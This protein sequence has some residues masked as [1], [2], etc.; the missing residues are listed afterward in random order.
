[1][2]KLPESMVERQLEKLQ[3]HLFVAYKQTDDTYEGELKPEVQ[4]IIHDNLQMNVV[5]DEEALVKILHTIVKEL[6]EWIKQE[7]KEI[8]EEILYRFCFDFTHQFFTKQLTIASADA[9]SPEF[10]PAY[11]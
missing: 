2:D 8:N 10:D 9:P 1:M 6:A 5:M 11:G 7:L 3:K 4:K